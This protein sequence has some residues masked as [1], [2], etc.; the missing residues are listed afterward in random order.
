MLR[1]GDLRKSMSSYLTERIE[2]SV[3]ITVMRRA[4]IRALH[5]ERSLAAVT[6]EHTDT[7]EHEELVC[8]AL[9]LFIGAVPRTEWLREASGG[10]SVALDDKDLIKTGA[11][12]TDADKNAA[13]RGLTPLPFETSLP[14]VFA[15][16]NV[17]SG[18]TKRVA[19]AVGEGSVAVK[20]VH[21]RLAVP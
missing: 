17:R 13:W 7:G 4:E 11:A 16:G 5:G 9:F 10:L 14:G 3:N 12:L 19:G 21:D 18:S 6:L 1:S 8:A 15:V 20:A 2:A